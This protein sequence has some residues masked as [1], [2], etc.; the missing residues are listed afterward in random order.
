MS[1]SIQIKSA[2]KADLKAILSL[3]RNHER[4]DVEFAKRY[5]NIYFGED[6]ITE[7]DKVYIAKI[8]EN[9]V[10]VIGFCRDY[11]LTDYSYWLGWFVVDKKYR[12]NKNYKVAKKLLNKVK[13]ELRKRNIKKLFVSTEDNNTRAKSF[14]AKNDFRTEAVLR[15]YYGEK[16]DQL[17]LSTEYHSV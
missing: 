16:E 8:D 11:L 7:K 14:Y 15:D 1:K 5:Y 9:L 17:I 10:G 3:I 2:E 13:D 4:Y 12:G 6:E